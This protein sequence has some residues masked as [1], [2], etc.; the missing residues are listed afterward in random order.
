MCENVQA[1]VTK[2]SFMAV[3][4][5]VVIGV[6]RIIQ[7]ILFDARL[8]IAATGFQKCLWSSLFIFIKYSI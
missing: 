5:L 8:E 4:E 6:S 7:G 3:S 1:W 2:K